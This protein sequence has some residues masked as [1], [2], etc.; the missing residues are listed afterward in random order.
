MFVTER[1]RPGVR[2]ASPPTQAALNATPAVADG[3]FG[4]LAGFVGSRTL[5]I[6]VGS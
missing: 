3:P 6:V 1:A 5:G 2:P 4:L